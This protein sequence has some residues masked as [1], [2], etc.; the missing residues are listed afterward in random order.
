VGEVAFDARMRALAGFDPLPRDLVSGL[1]AAARETGE[2][3]AMMADEN[4]PNDSQARA[5]K[6]L[7]HGIWTGPDEQAEPRR[8]AFA[9][10]LQWAAIEE[11]N[12]VISYCG[13]VPGFWA[14]PPRDTG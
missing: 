1:Y 3:E 13:G 14:E 5:L 6:A 4:R 12:N 11:T 10:A 7:Y 9:E 8:L 2:L